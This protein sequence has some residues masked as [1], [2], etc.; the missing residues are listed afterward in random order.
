MNALVA[1]VI[2][3]YVPVIV[4]QVASW[5]LLAHIV[6]PA[7]ALVGL[8]AFVG[9]LL[10]AIYYG[11]VRILEQQWPSFGV[12][13]GLTA[14][15]D[16]YSKSTETAAVPAAPT[17]NPAPVAEL[18]A[19]VADTSLPAVDGGFQSKIDAAI[20]GVSTV[21][22]PVPAPAPAPAAVPATPAQ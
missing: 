22:D 17:V 4:G 13:L 6:L 3:T 16:T 14:S 9:G 8:T 12:L 10:T 11:G 20:A 2:R 1:S 7:P 18:L 19:P 15:P 5:L 21:A